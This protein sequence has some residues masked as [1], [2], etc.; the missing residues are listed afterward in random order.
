[1]KLKD[2]SIHDVRQLMGGDTT[3][4]EASMMQDI[5][6]QFEDKYLDTKDI[7]DALWGDMMN[8]AI[9]QANSS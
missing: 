5:L 2:I 7:P 9:D 1:M 8:L 4:R 6:G 3:R